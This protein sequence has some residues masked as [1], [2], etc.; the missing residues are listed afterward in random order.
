V[1]THVGDSSLEIFHRFVCFCVARLI[2]PSAIH[3][4]FVLLVFFLLIG[5]AYLPVRKLIIVVILRGSETELFCCADF[6]FMS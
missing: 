4:L 3:W 1:R 2:V 6:S 5:L